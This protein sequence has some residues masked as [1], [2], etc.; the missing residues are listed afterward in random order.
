MCCQ[1]K[2]EHSTRLHILQESGG[3]AGDRGGDLPGEGGGGGAVAS[4]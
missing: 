3:G 2:V 4:R 1:C